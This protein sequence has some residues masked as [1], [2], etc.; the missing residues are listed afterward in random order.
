MSFLPKVAEI[1]GFENI[2]NITSDLTT[3][4]GLKP[5]KIMT[6]K[7]S[8]PT[9][10]FYRENIEI[11]DKYK[12]DKFWWLA[13][14]DSAEP[15]DDAKWIICVSPSGYTANNLYFISNGARPLLNFVSSIPVLFF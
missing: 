7:I 14:P 3:L 11:F 2:C 15:H 9:L 8:L 4:N 6:S 1:I 12:T 5:Y 10:D 13:T